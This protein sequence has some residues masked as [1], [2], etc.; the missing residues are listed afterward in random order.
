VIVVDTNLLVYLFVRGRRT[1]EA[2]AVLGKDAVWTAPW[3]WRSEFRNCL[4][5]LVRR[6]D[7]VF[8][9]A[10]RL[11]EEAE[12]WMEGREY[13][14]RSTQVLR[15]A[16]RSRCSAYDCEYVALAMDLRVPLITAD[17]QVLRGFPSVALS[18]DRFAA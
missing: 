5:G 9:D 4:A 1:E 17:Q 12:R 3:L 7:I 11:M 16:E 10:V 18:I 15:L 14:V 6:G 13:T 8:E 2:E